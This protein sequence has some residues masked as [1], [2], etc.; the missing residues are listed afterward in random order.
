MWLF[1]EFHDYLRF[2]ET[3]ALLAV[4]RKLAKREDLG[5]WGTRTRWRVFT[6]VYRFSEVVAG[7]DLEEWLGIPCE[8]EIDFLS[9]AK[10]VF[11]PTQK[12]TKVQK[13]RKTPVAM[14][15][16]KTQSKKEDSEE[17]DRSLTKQRESAHQL[18]RTFLKRR[19]TMFQF[20]YKLKVSE[21][22]KAKCERHPRYNPE[23]DGRG[24]IKEG[25]STCFS[26]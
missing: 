13:A 7:T 1:P 26:L 18:P 25:C 22:V 3:V 10:A 11:A 14:L 6:W 24:G 23:R 15:K 4:I 8:N 5:E 20:S 16:P 21:R 17:A 9:E 12:K 19:K 2:A